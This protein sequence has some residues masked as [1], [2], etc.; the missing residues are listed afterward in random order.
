ME[1]GKNEKHDGQN[2]PQLPEKAARITASQ[3]REVTARAE[4]SAE[5]T[6]CASA[7]SSCR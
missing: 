1:E 6:P 2:I 3:T 4:I 7:R 5:A